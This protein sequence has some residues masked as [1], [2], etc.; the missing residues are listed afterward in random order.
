MM[1][2]FQSV[3]L[4]HT[5]FVSSDDLSTIKFDHTT[6]ENTRNSGSI[7]LKIKELEGEKVAFINTPQFRASSEFNER[8]KFQKCTTHVIMKPIINRDENGKATL[9]RC[10]GGRHQLITVTPQVLHKSSPANMMS[11]LHHKL[12]NTCG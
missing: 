1:V 2:R 4:P 5:L 8:M 6:Q 7:E 3:H 10:G 12:M 9:K 11:S